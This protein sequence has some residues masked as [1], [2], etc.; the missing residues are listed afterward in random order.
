LNRESRQRP[1]LLLVHSFRSVALDVN[2]A[3]N[4]EKAAIRSVI[5]NPFTLAY[6]TLIGYKFTK[7]LRVI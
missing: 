7:I 4:G 6:L 5:P 3:K 1:S 2:R